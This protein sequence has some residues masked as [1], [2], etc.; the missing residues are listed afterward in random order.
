MP[1]AHRV[2]ATPPPT[3]G[4]RFTPEEHAAYLAGFLRGLPQSTAERV[5]ARAFAADVPAQ[6]APPNPEPE[7]INNELPRVLLGN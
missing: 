6:T 1:I 5:V 2:R 7:P 4:R 3:W